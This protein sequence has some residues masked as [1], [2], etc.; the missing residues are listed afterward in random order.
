MIGVLGIQDFFALNSGLPTEEEKSSLSEY[1]EIKKQLVKTKK[2]VKRLV[3]VLE[4]QNTVLRRLARKID[5][6]A[7]EDEENLG[8]TM[9]KEEK[10]LAQ[11]FLY[12]SR[13]DQL[14]IEASK[15]RPYK[16]YV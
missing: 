16:T 4:T 7:E 3:N 12:D 10:A 13:D 5:P 2:R 1:A 8:L 15:D 6:E 14:P 9:I 11:D